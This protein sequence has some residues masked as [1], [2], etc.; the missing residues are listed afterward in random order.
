VKS[1]LTGAKTS[2]DNANSILE[3]MAAQVR[4]HL[5]DIDRLVAE[6]SADERSESGAAE[7]PPQPEPAQESLV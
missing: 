1:S 2:I 4:E 6:G 5:R 3:D 7:P